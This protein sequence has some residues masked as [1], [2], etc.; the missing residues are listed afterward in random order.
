MLFNSIPTLLLIISSSALIQPSFGL[1]SPK[2]S[3][4]WYSEYDFGD[5]IYSDY[6]GDYGNSVSEKVNDLAKLCFPKELNHQA[7]HLLRPVIGWLD[8]VEV[9]KEDTLYNTEKNVMYNNEE[10]LQQMIATLSEE[11]A[12]FR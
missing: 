11:V 5:Y 4:V 12:N 6:Y 3:N 8:A 2:E 10:N 7:I 1:P 9:T